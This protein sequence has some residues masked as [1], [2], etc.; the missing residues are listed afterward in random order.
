M[1]QRCLCTALQIPSNVNDD[2]FSTALA[3]YDNTDDVD[4]DYDGTDDVN[5]FND[6]RDIYENK[7]HMCFCYTKNNAGSWG[8]FLYTGIFVVFDQIFQIVFTLK[9]LSQDLEF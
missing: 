3:F 9:F 6:D 1:I 4:H 7:Q 8:V 2:K 5:D